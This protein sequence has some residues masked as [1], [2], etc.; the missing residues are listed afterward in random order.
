[1]RTF[2]SKTNP[3]PE[4]G[5]V[6]NFWGNYGIPTGINTSVSERVNK[7]LERMKEETDKSIRIFMLNQ[8]VNVRAP[9]I[10]ACLGNRV[11]GILLE[12]G[13][14]R[15]LTVK[16]DTVNNNLIEVQ[17]VASNIIDEPMKAASRAFLIDQGIKD[18]ELINIAVIPKD[19]NLE[20]ESVIGYCMAYLRLAVIPNSRDVTIQQ[21]K[22]NDAQV[23]ISHNFNPAATFLT[24]LGRPLASDVTMSVTAAK[25]QTRKEQTTASLNQESPGFTLA[26]VNVTIDALYQQPDVLATLQQSG[27]LFGDNKIE[28]PYIPLVVINDNNGLSPNGQGVESLTNQFIGIMAAAQLTRRGNWARPWQAIP[29]AVTKKTCLGNVGI[30]CNLLNDPAFIPGPLKVSYAG[31]A[32]SS[33]ITL[34]VL[35]N[36]YF[37]PTAL[38]AIDVEIGSANQF[39]QRELL[40]CLDSVKRP[41]AEKKIRETLDRFTGNKFSA[42]LPENTRMV[43]TDFA[44]THAGHFRDEKTNSK[45]DI[46]SIDYFSKLDAWGNDPA[47]MADLQVIPRNN[48]AEKLHRRAKILQ[49][50]VP[51]FEQTGWKIRLYLTPEMTNALLLAAQDAELVMSSENMDQNSP[52]QANRDTGLGSLI[53]GLDKSQA[54]DSLFSGS[55]VNSGEESLFNDSHL[56]GLL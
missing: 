17:E 53:A 43:S 9:I 14:T 52:D 33:A 44:R 11:A 39:A 27:A 23:S 16:T 19:A 47:A 28:A 32:D 24:T 20:D 1:M 25:K 48:T 55:S 41:A 30:E 13:I 2:E 22:D 36:S 5:K 56:D 18:P 7:M 40:N 15:P 4:E 21:L 51:S 50:A 42:R 38:L 46:N 54:V 12:E 6:E 34:P 45:V 49:G 31:V 35:V 26:N 3:N 8:P 37:K 10:F 29:G